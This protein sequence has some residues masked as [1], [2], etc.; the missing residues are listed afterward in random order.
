MLC[1]IAEYFYEL[2]CIFEP[3][4]QVKRVTILSDTTQKKNLIRDLL[5]NMPNCCA[6][7]GEFHGY[8]FTWNAREKYAKWNRI[9]MGNPL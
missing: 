8:P 7:A 9:G 4:G 3:T 2:S 5:S 6:H 1:S